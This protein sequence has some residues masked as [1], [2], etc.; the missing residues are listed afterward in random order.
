MELLTLWPLSQGELEGREEHFVDALFS[1]Q[2]EHRAYTTSR[3]DLLRRMA[4]GGFPEAVQR[5][6]IRRRV[7]YDSYVTTILQR[8]IRDMA[9]VEGLTALPRLLSLIAARCGSLLNVAEVSRTSGLPNSTLRRYLALFEAAFLVQTIPA[10]AAG[11]ESRLVKS[12]RVYLSD[13]GLACHLNGVDE[14]KLSRDPNIAGPLFENF[15][16]MEL[17]KQCTWSR[18]RAQLFH[19]RL[20]TGHEVDLLL[21]R[22]DG[23]VVGVEVKFA[24]TVGAAD[25]KGLKALREHAGNRFLRGILLYGGS[26]SIALGSDLHALPVDALWAYPH[27]GEG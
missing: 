25:L 18:T 5:K 19:Y 7:W 11:L 17:R 23:V 3:S 4:A 13:S 10:W 8:N 21:E 12:P 15:V 9:N 20:H 26:E 16:A 6:P 2:L 24:A 27:Q 1:D 14:E 22:D